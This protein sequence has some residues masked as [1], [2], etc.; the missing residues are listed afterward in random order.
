VEQIRATGPRAIVG[1][2]NGVASPV[3]G[4]ARPAP[5]HA[6]SV[7]SASEAPSILAGTVPP[8]GPNGRHR[9][10]FGGAHVYSDE[11]GDAATDADDGP[12]SGEGRP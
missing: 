2:L 11:P 12:G 9:E 7:A 8:R 10:Q 3:N 6:E 5:A 1:V 4:R